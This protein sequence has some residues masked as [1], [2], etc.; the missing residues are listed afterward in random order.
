MTK[1]PHTI[2][3]YR[4]CSRRKRHLL[5]SSQLKVTIAQIRR[6]WY[7]LQFKQKT[8]SQRQAEPQA[9]AQPCWSVCTVQSRRILEPCAP[10]QPTHNCDKPPL[11]KQTGRDNTISPSD[12]LSVKLASAKNGSG[13]FIPERQAHQTIL[14]LET[15]GAILLET[16]KKCCP[17]SFQEKFCKNDF[18]QIEEK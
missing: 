10:R 13:S 3:N 8:P 5:G 2:K 15:C 6:G 18:W 4:R 14:K 17:L 9:A 1:L 11:K 12:N 7:P 16:R